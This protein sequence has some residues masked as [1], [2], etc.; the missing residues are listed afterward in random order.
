MCTV[1]YIPFNQTYFITSNRDESPGRQSAGLI[2]AHSPDWHTI[3]FPLDELSAG[4]WIALADS[5]KAVCLLN[6]GFE[7]FIPSPPYRLSRGQVVLDTAKSIDTLSFLQELTLDHIAPFTLLNFEKDGF[8]QLVWDGKEK[9]FSTL[10]LD[11]PQIWSSVTLYPK[12][13]RE[14]RKSLFEKWLES[15]PAFTRESIIDFHRMANGDPDNDFVM[16]RHDIVK[17]LSVTSIELHDTSGS[18]L[19]IALDKVSRE[20]I[21]V[22]YDG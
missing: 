20:E 4:S 18:I 12:H 17:T 11:Q 3:H 5:G 16:N 1:T 6:G 21:K 9:H 13:V 14:W 19:H 15:G 10:P 2:S 7:P 8:T 22:R